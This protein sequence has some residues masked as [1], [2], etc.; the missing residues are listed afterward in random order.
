MISQELLAPATYE[1]CYDINMSPYAG[2][3][4]LLFFTRL[5]EHGTTYIAEKTGAPYSKS[6]LAK[7]LRFLELTGFYLP[8]NFF[9]SVV[10]HEVFG[11]GY[12]IRDI[13]N[14]KMSVTGYQFDW[15]PPYGPGNAAT[16][17]SFFPSQVT[18]TDLTCI[19]M[20]GLE[21]QAILAEQTAHKWLEGRRID[22]RQTVLYLASRFA[23]NLYAPADELDGHDI[24]EYV[25]SLN[26][27]YTESACTTKQL[28][29]LSWINFADPFTYYSIYA[30]FHYIVSGK[31]TNIPMIPIGGYGYLFGARLGLTPFGPEYFFDNY[32]AKGN[33]PI[34]FYMKGGNHAKNTYL[35][36]GFLAP[37]LLIDNHWSLGVRFDSWWQPKLL[38]EAGN[39]P[40]TEIDFRDPPSPLYSEAEQH[41]HHCGCAAS[42][43]GAYR[44]NKALGLQAE[45]GVKTAGFLPGYSLRPSPVVRI[46]YLA[47]F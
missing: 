3:E 26:W 31:E 44:A 8:L 2:G 39:Q 24:A 36:L 5:A 40:L 9:T 25:Q 14:G 7:S 28:E 37:R 38:L 45:L 46:S 34:Y 33:N 27:T 12:R 20:A 11:H 13:D 30:W 1:I 10:E 23:L 16:N 4:D 19:S 32:L 35:G 17:F 6:W 42:L 47:S 22:P 41:A 29:T 21:A 18:T 43:I 15:P